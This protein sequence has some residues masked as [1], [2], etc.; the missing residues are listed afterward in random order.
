[1][2]KLLCLLI[3]AALALSLALPSLAQTPDFGERENVS[4]VIGGSQISKGTGFL[5]N[6][7]FLTDADMETIAAA[8]SGEATYRLGLG[9]SFSELLTYSTYENHGTPTWIYR[10]VCGLDLTLLA[11]ALGINTAQRMSI[12][13]SSPDGM[14]K[15]LSDAFMYE[16]TRYTYGTDGLTSAPIGPVLALFE[17]SSETAALG[18]GVLPAMPRTGSGSG[19]RV[20][21]VFGYGQTAVDEINSC[22]W[23]KEVNRLRFGS[24]N[25]A[26]TVNSAG[27]SLSTSVSGIVANGVW[28]TAFGSVNALGIPMNELLDAMGV[29][30]SG[31]QCIRA[32]AS[33]GQAVTVR[34]PSG[35]FIAWQAADGGSAVKNSTALRLYTVDGAVLGDLE[36][37]T[38]EEYASFTDIDSVP[39]AVD[40]VDRLRDLGIVTGR[41]GGLFA[42]TENIKR[43]DFILMLSR[44]YGFSGGADG[45]FSD[46]PESSY[47]YSAIAG[48][49]ALG[50]AR[51]D[52]GSFFPEDT[53]TRQEAMTLLCRTMDACGVSLGLG[54][55]ELDTYSDAGD[56][57]SWALDSVGRLVFAGVINGKGDRVDP[58]GKM[59]RAEMAVA[60]CRALDLSAKAN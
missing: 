26:L 33:D 54:S 35:A 25:A 40:A 11:Q 29:T 6:F 36:S 52:G 43:G 17:T 55:G 50:I 15:T 58:L 13:V 49:K 60:L 39:W 5:K 23:V 41:N 18:S 46:V 7:V 20:N 32:A 44:A 53:I 10:R 37:L 30:V 59:T 8:S 1:M 34:D 24:E 21:N 9:D 51:G 2:K 14:S 16:T 28:R 4:L 48:A 12:S 56:I 47:Y 27:K 45:N 57:A 31:A 22:Y 38:V 42:P 3:T 19:D